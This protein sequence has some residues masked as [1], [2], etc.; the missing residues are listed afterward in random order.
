MNE[1]KTYKYKNKGISIYTYILIHTHSKIK[2]PFTDMAS[3]SMILGHYYFCEE[4]QLCKGL[5][6][7]YALN[8][9]GKAPERLPNHLLP[10]SRAE[11][12]SC[13][14]HRRREDNGSTQNGLR[15]ADS[16]HLTLSASMLASLTKNTA[17]A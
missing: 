7:C 12:K 3:R 1:C 8:E 9:R 10:L 14:I 15:P 5:A 6:L 11:V 16:R 17:S 2:S 13:A 4:N